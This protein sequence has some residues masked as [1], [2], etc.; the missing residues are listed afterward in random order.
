M[1][2]DLDTF[3]TTVYCIVDDLYREKFAH[4]KPIRP[5]QEPEMT[6]S[7]VLTVALLAQWQQSRSERDFLRHAVKH[8]RGYFP[9]LLSQSA[10]NKR[11]RDLA[12][13]LCCLGPAI[14]EKLAAF[15]GCKP[16]YEAMDGVPVP[17]MRRCRGRRTRL[18]ANEANF[19]RGGSD[20]EWYYGVKLLVVVNNAGAITG[21]S[22]GPANTEERWLAEALLR[23]RQYSLAAAPTAEELGTI[24]GPAH[25]NG[26]QRLGPSGP[27]A[28]RNGVGKP[29]D[30]PILGDLGF[31]GKAWTKHWWRDYGVK[32]LTKQDYAELASDARREASRWLNGLR[33]M[34]ETTFS[35]LCQVFG[36]KFCRARS[37]WGLLARIGAKI[38][39]FNVGVL[40]NHLF[41]RPT[42]SFFNPLD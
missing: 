19:G 15:P 11:V 7:E 18:F 38:A 39:A 36:L 2:T 20:K 9:L 3:L 23:W 16:S 28:G 29:T 13:V 10:F 6:D 27:I 8:W 24:L 5:G 21:F 35:G 22:F 1:E 4:L 30:V 41:S 42:L 31:R 14:A 25:R 37:A 34:V 17:L 26:G 33:Q 12:G 40:I 32:V